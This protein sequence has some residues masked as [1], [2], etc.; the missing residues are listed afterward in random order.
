M[1]RPVGRFVTR[2]RGFSFEVEDGRSPIGCTL[3][4]SQRVDG[5]AGFRK[6]ETRFGRRTYRRKSPSIRQVNMFKEQAGLGTVRQGM[7]VDVLWRLLAGMTGRS[8]EG[9]GGS[10]RLSAS[11]RA[12]RMSSVGSSA[13]SFRGRDS[14]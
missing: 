13:C 11:I 12:I 6:S 8:L 9:R 4:S 10:S 7:V 2:V 5:A 3:Y 14:E 1:K